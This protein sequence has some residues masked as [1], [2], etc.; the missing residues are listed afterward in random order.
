[1]RRLTP[2]DLPAGITTTAQPLPGNGRIYTFTHAQLGDLGRLRITPH[3]P[4]QILA[5]AEIAP[6]DPDAPDWERKYHM[7][8]Q[9]ITTCLNAL[10]GG[11]DHKPLTNMDEM[12]EQRRLFRRLVDV[13][14]SIQMFGLAKALSEREYLILVKAVQDALVTAESSDAIGLRQRLEELNFYWHDLKERPTV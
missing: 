5:S 9:V 4:N 8:D 11:G 12:R 7:L 10:P 6:G 14:H 2:G 3:G 1:M 13:Q